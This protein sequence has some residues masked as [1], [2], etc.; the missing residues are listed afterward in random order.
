MDPQ[1]EMLWLRRLHQLSQRLA[2]ETNLKELLP[3]ILDAAI[4][5]AQAERGFLV[6]SEGKTSTGRPRIRVD[7]ARGF[8]KETLAGARGKMSFAKIRPIYREATA[9]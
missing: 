3:A 5:L 8:A 9:R 4:E 1:R 7:A 2:Q 6:R